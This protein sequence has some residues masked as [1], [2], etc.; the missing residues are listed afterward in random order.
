MHQ[1]NHQ[2]LTLHEANFFSF[3]SKNHQNRMNILVYKIKK[4]FT[5]A[6][7]TNQPLHIPM[8]LY[9]FFHVFTEKLYLLESYIIIRFTDK[10]YQCKLINDVREYVKIFQCNYVCIIIG[11]CVLGK[12]TICIVN[13]GPLWG[14]AV[15]HGQ[16]FN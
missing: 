3:L 7:I 6:P 11:A 16:K 8:Y 9:G 10:I 4:Q 12:L 15:Y 1:K 13:A 2:D 14:P 5:L